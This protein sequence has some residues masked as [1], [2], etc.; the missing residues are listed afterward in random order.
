VLGIIDAIF[1]FGQFVEGNIIAPKL[2]GKSVGMHPVWIF[3]AL[4]ACGSLFGILGM[5]LAVPVA[6]VAGVLIAFGVKNYKQS[7]IYKGKSATRKR[8]S[9]SKVRK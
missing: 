8:K 2:I 7:T 1:L 4:I 3:F 6:A 5:F 9:K